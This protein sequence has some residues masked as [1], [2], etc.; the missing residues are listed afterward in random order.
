M[1]VLILGANGY[2]GARIYFDL[3]LTHDCTGTYHNQQLS[4]KFL[5]LDIT[6]ENT[7]RDFIK[8]NKPDYIIHSANNANA[9][10]CNANPESAKLLNQTATDYIVKAANL[11]KAKLIYIS[12]VVTPGVYGDMKAAS[13]E[14]VKNN[15]AGFCIIKPRFILGFSPNTVNDR[16][17]NRILNNIDQKTPAIYDTSWKLQVTYLRHISEVIKAVIERNIFGETFVVASPGMHT[18]FDTAEDIL[19]AFSIPVTPID[20]HDSTPGIE[21]DLSDLANLRLPR[22][23]Y[24]EVIANIVDE[25]KHRER[26]VI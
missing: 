1:K 5:K 10:W 18:R 8:F 25:I 4:A 15:T 26:F 3:Q 19:S 14:I 17:F 12:T 9:R 24:M 6:Q 2:V 11:V 13:D 21:S 23:A 7:V 16:P 20:N 22:Y